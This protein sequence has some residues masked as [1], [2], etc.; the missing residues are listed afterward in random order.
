MGRPKSLKVEQ[1]LNGLFPLDDD[2]HY[3][4]AVLEY[5]DNFLTVTVALLNI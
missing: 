1:S 3:I 4:T 5:L 2:D